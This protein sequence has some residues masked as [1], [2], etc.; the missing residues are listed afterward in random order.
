M[1]M[2]AMHEHSHT[3]HDLAEKRGAIYPYELNCLSNLF[4]V[5]RKVLISTSTTAINIVWANIS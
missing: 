5:V 2:I 1:L 3:I 4:L